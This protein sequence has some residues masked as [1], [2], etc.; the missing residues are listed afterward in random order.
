MFGFQQPTN[1]M[2]TIRVTLCSGVVYSQDHSAFIFKNIEGQG[3]SYFN[4]SLRTPESPNPT[5]RNTP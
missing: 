4:V 5:P 3:T 2:M 1:H